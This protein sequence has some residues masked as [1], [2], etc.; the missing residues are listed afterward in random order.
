MRRLGAGSGSGSEV[1]LGIRDSLPLG[2]A[3]IPVGIA[4]GYAAQAVGLSWWLAG[5]MSAVVYAGPSQ[6]IATGMIAAN[7]AVPA[8]AATTFVANLRYSLFAASLGRHMHGTPSWRLLALGHAV[9]DGSYAVT[10]N[11]L[12]AEPGRPGADRY[13]LG[14][15]IVSFG[16]WVPGTVLGALSGKIVGDVVAFGLG[17]A[18]PAIF[19][20]FLIPYVRDRVAVLVLLA[21][22]LGTVVGNELLPSGTGPLIA[23][24][25]ASILGGVLRSRRTRR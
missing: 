16:F 23:I 4:F 2:F 9:V 21:S 12:L 22:G 6:F 18:T 25:G 24:I 13:L 7:A 15:F 14:S 3:L 5:L 19:I 8:I 20:A 11:R 1:A 10:M 17:F